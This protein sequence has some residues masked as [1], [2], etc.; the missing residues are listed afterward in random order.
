MT[1]THNTD[2]PVGEMYLCG[3]DTAITQLRFG[4]SEAEAPSPLLLEAEKELLE[5]FAGKRKEFDLP[6][7]PEGTGFQKKVWQALRDI[8][9]GETRSYGEIAAAVGN[10]KACRAVGMA[11]NRNPIAIITPCHRVIGADGKLTGYAG[12]LGIK[13]FLLEHERRMCL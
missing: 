9:F 10:P 13:E 6:L 7:E 12:G 3:N 4:H 1:Y 8:P 2:T 11:N 5:Y